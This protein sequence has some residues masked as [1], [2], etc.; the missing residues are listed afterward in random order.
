MENALVGLKTDEEACAAAPRKTSQ[1]FDEFERLQMIV[2]LE[3]LDDY[4]ASADL[5]GEEVFKMELLSA[6]SEKLSLYGTCGVGHCFTGF[7]CPFSTL[8]SET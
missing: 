8:E 3:Q 7:G 4:C 1:V 5:P 6:R 2:R